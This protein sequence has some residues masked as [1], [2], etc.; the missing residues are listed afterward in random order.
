MSGA[1]RALIVVV[2][3]GV[4]AAGAVGAWLLLGNRGAHTPGCI[5]SP[6]AN[7]TAGNAANFQLTPE[8][9][10]NAATIAAVGIQLGM[11]DHAVTIALA[12]ALQE[13]GLSNLPGGDRDSAGLFQQRPS[14][15]WGTYAQITD[16]VHA[17]TAFYQ[18]LRKQPDWTQLS[19]TQAAQRVQHSAAPDAYATWEPEARAAAAALTGEKASALTCHDLAITPKGA[20]IVDVALKELGTA[21]LSGA[22]GTARG[23]ALASWLVAH[24]L[25]LGVDSVTFDGR[26]WTASSGAWAQTGS[27]NGVL[28]LHQITATAP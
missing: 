14:Q 13:S 8:Q 24:A 26:T 9:A 2:V 6:T 17:A 22:H 16:P 7:V 1:G 23:W 28:S 21:K 12:T 19:V 5:V 15:G 27:P 3:V 18:R 20:S 25:R 11:P 4:V 10:G